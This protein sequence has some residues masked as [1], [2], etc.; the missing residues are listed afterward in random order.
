M[1]ILYPILQIS[2]NRKTFFFTAKYGWI[3]KQTYLNLEYNYKNSQKLSHDRIRRVKKISAFNNT[4]KWDDDDA[5][6]SIWAR[7]DFVMA[8]ATKRLF[9]VCVPIEFYETI[10]ETLETHFKISLSECEN[11]NMKMKAIPIKLKG[12]QDKNAAEW[13]VDKRY[14]DSI[15]YDKI[16]DDKLFIDYNVTQIVRIEP[17]II[18]GVISFNKFD[19]DHAIKALREVSKKETDRMY[20]VKNNKY[21]IGL[22][23]RDSFKAQ[24][25]IQNKSS[26]SVSTKHNKKTTTNKRQFSQTNENDT[27][28]NIKPQNEIVHQTVLMCPFSNCKLILKAQDFVSHLSYHCIQQNEINNNNNDKQEMD[29]KSF[30][31][32]IKIS[33]PTYQYYKNDNKQLALKQ[34]SSNNE[35]VN[36]ANIC[37]NCLLPDTC[38]HDVF[39]QKKGGNITTYHVSDCIL[40]LKR[41]YAAAN[42]SA[43]NNP[44]SNVAVKCTECPN[45][46]PK[47][48]AMMHYGDVHPQNI[49]PDEYKMSQEVLQ[50]IYE[51]ESARK[52]LKFGLLGVQLPPDIEI[53][54][55]KPSKGLINAANKWSMSTMPPPSKKQKLIINSD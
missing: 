29:A 12:K 27:K 45:I 9:Y 47:I 6:T 13:I 8:M 41:N 48:L 38:N 51:F 32:S 5:C 53:D 46:F 16:S 44:C 1:N 37:I 34:F 4:K 40:Y 10:N 21:F 23:F 20:D 31:Y 19:F 22:A 52:T 2:K 18:N 24:P 50:N 28:N 43:P 26:K 15:E 14:F 25:R 3:H 17:G 54:S 39:K 35:M 55:A 49:V 36:P 33:T 7:Y 30:S 42:K 11:E